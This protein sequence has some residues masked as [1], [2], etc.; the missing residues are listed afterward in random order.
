M[1]DVVKGDWLLV[2]APIG[3]GGDPVGVVGVAIPVDHVAAATEAGLAFVIPAAIVLLVALAIAFLLARRA[4]GAAPVLTPAHAAAAT[5]AAAN[6]GPPAAPA[7]A[8]ADRVALV[9]ALIEV[10][11]QVT[12]VTLGDVLDRA[13]AAAGVQPIS[14]DGEA[15]DARI[16]HAVASTP[17]TDAG[18]HDRI[19]ST[20]K[21]GYADGDRLIRPPQVVVYQFAA[22]QP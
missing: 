1:I 17:T 13:L 9:D 5:P 3:T 15:F 14:A 12:S 10:R 22:S 21:L 2:V 11:D 19:A 4:G 18:L 20:E 8:P 16:H 7:T 6:A